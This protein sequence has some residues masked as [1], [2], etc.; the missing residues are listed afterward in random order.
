FTVQSGGVGGAGDFVHRL[1]VEL[2]RRVEPEADDLHPRRE[3]RPHRLLERARVR[4]VL[5]HQ[6][7]DGVSATS[8]CAGCSS[9]ASA[10]ASAAASTNGASSAKV[11]SK[12]FPG[13]MSVLRGTFRWVVLRTARSTVPSG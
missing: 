4:L 11:G 7:S 6:P 1:P 13:S 10:A 2:D 5:S 9:A 12:N 8:A 3:R